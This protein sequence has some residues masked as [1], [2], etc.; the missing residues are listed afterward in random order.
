MKTVILSMAVIFITATA[1]SQASE[2]ILNANGE[3]KVKGKTVQTEL[4]SS[5]NKGDDKTDL[6]DITG[7]GATVFTSLNFSN[8]VPRNVNHTYKITLAIFTGANKTSGYQLVFPPEGD[9]IPIAIE[10]QNGITSIYFPMNTY[11]ALSQ[12]FEQS[13]AAKKRIQLKIIQNPSGYREGV[14]IF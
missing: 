8:N 11:A 9:A 14:L 3:V 2:T 4:L 10:A 6:L 13:L 7:I 12:K 1:F 5:R